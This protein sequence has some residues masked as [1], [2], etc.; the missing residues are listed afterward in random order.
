MMEKSKRLLKRMAASGAKV[1]MMNSNY[2]DKTQ[3]TK[4][5]S[6]TTFP[7]LKM[8][9]LASTMIK[10]K[11]RSGNLKY[12]SMAPQLTTLMAPQFRQTPEVKFLP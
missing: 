8:A 12:M 3:K 11:Y 5:A 1:M 10:Y 2:T 6:Q 9:R 4:S 7:P